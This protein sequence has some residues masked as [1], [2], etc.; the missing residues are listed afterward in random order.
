MKHGGEIEV[1][2]LSNKTVLK[3]KTPYKLTPANQRLFIQPN[4]EGNAYRNR[5]NH[6][7]MK[8]MWSL[9]HGQRTN[10]HT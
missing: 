6:P 3:P 1:L 8:K 10:T 5:L 2:I 7:T 4:D 9:D